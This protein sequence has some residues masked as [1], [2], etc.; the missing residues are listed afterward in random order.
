MKRHRDLLSDEKISAAI[1]EVQEF[2]HSV[3]DKLDQLSLQIQRLHIDD[4]GQILGHREALDRKRQFILS[5]L[6]PPDTESD[7]ERALK[8]R[9]GSKCGDWLESEAAFPVRRTIL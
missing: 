8:E 7:L 4:E 2:R 3:E 1:I 9:T 5:K 6:E